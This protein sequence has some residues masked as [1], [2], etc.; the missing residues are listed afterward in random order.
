VLAALGLSTLFFTFTWG[1]YGPL[2]FL[3]PIIVSNTLSFAVHLDRGYRRLA[4]LVGCLA[5]AVPAVLEIV[6]L[7]EPSYRFVDG[8]MILRAQT[9]ELP[10][11]PTLLVLTAGGVASLLTGAFVV[12]GVR[13]TLR[14][15]EERLYLYAWHLRE[16]VPQGARPSTDPVASRE[17]RHLTL[18]GMKAVTGEEDL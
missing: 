16:F 8:A 15:A 14:E 6:G 5:L 13:D 2:I 9:L 17:L 1:F 12:G 18:D 7:V 10:A 4:V 3:P 11:M